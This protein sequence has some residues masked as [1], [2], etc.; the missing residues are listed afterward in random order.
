MNTSALDRTIA[1]PRALVSWAALYG[2]IA[3]DVVQVFA[4]VY[5][6]GFTRPLLIAAA[7]VAFIVELLLL[8]VALRRISS[9]V[10]YGLFGLSTASVAAVS[11]GWL[12]EPLTPVKAIALL[13]VVTGAVLLNTE[14][15]TRKARR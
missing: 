10:A 1:E 15:T 6:D 3:L 5:S 8:A 2:A 11:I 12:G 9:S 14:P 4:L 13:A 7:L